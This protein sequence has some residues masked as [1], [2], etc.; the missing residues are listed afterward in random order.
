MGFLGLPD[1]VLKKAA[2]KS[3]EFETMYGKRTRTNQNQI[4][5]MLQSLN[6]CHGNGILDLQNRAK[7]FLE[8]K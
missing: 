1:A 2:I 6:N 5:L 8:H 7:I 3:Q 4:A